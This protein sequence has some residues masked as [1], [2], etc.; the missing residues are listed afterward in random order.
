MSRASWSALN[1]VSRSPGSA[2][3]RTPGVSPSALNPALRGFEARR[4]V[5]LR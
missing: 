3:A 4:V 2:A 1:V 5:R